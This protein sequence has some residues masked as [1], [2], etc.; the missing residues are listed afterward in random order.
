MTDAFQIVQRRQQQWR[1][2]GKA[3][4]TACEVAS[5]VPR[6]SRV[7]DVGCGEGYVAHHLTSLL[8][9]NV[10]GI[11]LANTTDAPIE[12]LSYDGIRFPVND[13][14]FDG[15]LLSYVLHHAQNVHTVLSEVRRVLRDGGFAIVYEDIPQN[16][17]DRFLCWTHDRKWRD[18]TGPC[19][20]R[21]EAEWSELFK[22]S[23]LEIVSEQPLSRWRDVFHPVSR[24]LYVLK[25]NGH[26][27]YTADPNPQ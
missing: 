8:R 21:C 12:Y 1:V 20:F 23:G 3:Y 17:W 24:R 22:K 10:L 26:G 9:T 14:S 4:D 2:V 7:L 25:T 13:Q 11:D 15:V 5:V 16:G 27:D 6:D 18:R 19:T